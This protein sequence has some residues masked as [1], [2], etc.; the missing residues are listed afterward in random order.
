MEH[1]EENLWPPMEITNL[2]DKLLDRKIDI[3]HFVYLFVF[4]V[5]KAIKDCTKN[6]YFFGFSQA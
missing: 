1:Q 2:P 6:P 4:I 3:I 5:S